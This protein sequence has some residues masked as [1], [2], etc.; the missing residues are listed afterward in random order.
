MLVSPIKFDIQRLISNWLYAFETKVDY[1]T[2]NSLCWVSSHALP[3]LFYQLFTFVLDL[4]FQI[5]FK[6]KEEKQKSQ[7]H[8]L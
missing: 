6:K 7:S 2:L 8:F 1:P 3:V 4:I 5:F